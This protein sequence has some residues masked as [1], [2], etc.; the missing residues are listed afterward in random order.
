VA[1]TVFIA[2]ALFRVWL[3]QSAEC[4]SGQGGQGGQDAVVN[5]GGGGGEGQAN[6]GN[7]PYVGNKKKADIVVSVNVNLSSS[8]G[9]GEEEREK[10]QE[11]WEKTVRSVSIVDFGLF[12][13]SE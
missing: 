12:G 1:D 3:E 9:K 11:W 6:G 10:V 8:D 4:A 13:D 7:T 2:V 5:G